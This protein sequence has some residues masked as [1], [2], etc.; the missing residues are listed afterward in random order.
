VR[1]A[2]SGRSRAAAAELLGVDLRTLQRWR[3]HLDANGGAPVG[4]WPRGAEGAGSRGG[5]SPATRRA[6]RRASVNCGHTMT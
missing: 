1:A 4:A 3:A 5:T 2:L 6:A